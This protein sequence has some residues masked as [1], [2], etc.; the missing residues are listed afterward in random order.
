MRLTSVEERIDAW[1]HRRLAG[2]PE[3][4]W[5]AR[6]IEC[7]VFVLKQ[8]WACIFGAALLAVIVAAKL[9]YPDDAGLARND[10]LVI[11]AVS[12]QVLMLVFRLETV[13]EASVIV[14]FHVVGTVMEIFKTDMGSWIYSGEGVLHLAGVPLYSGFMYA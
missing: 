5:R 1:A 3:H 10:A 7:V 14:L 12:I 13:R 8:A 4:G 2:A 11:A 6:A 9:W